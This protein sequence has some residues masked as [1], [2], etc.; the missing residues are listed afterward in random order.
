MGLPGGLR[1][2]RADRAPPGRPDLVVSGINL[3]PN[4]PGSV[5]LLRHR[6]GGHGAS[7]FGLPAVA[8]STEM[9]GAEVDCLP[10]AEIAR[11]ILTRLQGHGRTGAAH[12]P[13]RELPRPGPQDLPGAQD[14]AARAWPPSA[15]AGDGR[16]KT[17]GCGWPD[18]PGQ[19]ATT[20]WTST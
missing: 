6:G 19:E 7:F 17:G 3:G 14:H 15:T 10:L 9:N 12:G 8:F 20:A 11:G 2:M 1:E 13:Q 4:L 16:G 18:E 5:F